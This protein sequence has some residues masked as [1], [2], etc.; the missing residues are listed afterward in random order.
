MKLRIRG[1]SVRVRLTQSEVATLGAG[2][3][4]Q[5]TTEFSVSSRLECILV[6]DP[7]A[8]ELTA[9]FRDGQIRIGIPLRKARLWADSE[10]VGVEGRQPVA[11]DR[12][13]SIL[14]E[15]DF[16]CLHSRAEDN[17]DTFPNP[18]NSQNATTQ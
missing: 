9:T 3:S 12:S 1:N 2:Q 10:D 7:G 8:G 4:V 18:R 6:T 17:I 11:A 14:L 13:L 16:E 5:Q 15:K